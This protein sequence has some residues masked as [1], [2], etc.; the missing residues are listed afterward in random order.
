MNL[1][2][3][4]LALV[5]FLSFAVAWP[6]KLEVPN[7]KQDL[8]LVYHRANSGIS[9]EAL[10]GGALVGRDCSNTLN[11]GS[12][13]KLPVTFDVDE[14]GS[15]N[16]TVGPST[17]WIHE[18]TDYSGGIT[19]SRMYND[20]EAAVYCTVIVPAEL[21]ISPSTG[22]DIT[23][24][25]TNHAHSLSKTLKAATRGLPLRNSI[26]QTDIEPIS[27]RQG[28]VCIDQ[29]GTTRWACGD[30]HQNFYHRQLSVSDYFLSGLLD[31]SIKCRLSHIPRRHKHVNKN[32]MSSTIHCPI[33]LRTYQEAHSG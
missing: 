14:R 27:P 18:H 11:T 5:P 17:Y 9:V 19:C 13:A 22:L 6:T 1:F 23:E 33:S 7:D 10:S 26:N 15:G 8:T 30:P 31:P 3:L 4:I 25:N 21:S 12:F 29:S 20:M 24:C 28:S 16:L 32:M 2:T